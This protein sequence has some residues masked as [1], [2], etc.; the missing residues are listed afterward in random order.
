[1]SEHFLTAPLMADKARS[2]KLG[3]IVFLSG[4]FIGTAGYPTHK[5]LHDGIIRGEPPPI[6]MHGSAFF[7]LGSMSRE[8]DGRITPLYVNPTTST[9]FSAFI[10]R[11]VR[12]FGIT[13]L[14]GKGGLDAECVAAMREVGCVYFS[15]IGGSA[16]LLTEGVK[17]VL[18]TGWDDL[19]M[20]FRLTRFRIENFGPLAVAIDAHGRSVYD[21]L[22]ASAR[23]RLPEIMAR[24]NAERS[25]SSH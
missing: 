18:E 22:T 23:G 20:Q 16:P 12:H 21:E 10:P 7:H 9:R 5:R 25:R 8:T 19:I 3:D 6:S 2:L 13:A 1:M 14:A 24:L 11:I 4:E 15:M 17:E